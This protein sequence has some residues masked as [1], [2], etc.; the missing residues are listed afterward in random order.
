[1]R[2][3]LLPDQWLVTIRRLVAHAAVEGLLDRY[4]AN[5]N[6][7]FVIYNEDGKRVG[8]ID[9]LAI[10][11]QTAFCAMVKLVRFRVT[12][13][14]V[15]QLAPQYCDVWRGELRDEDAVVILGK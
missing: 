5:P 8:H 7:F 9:I 2:R 3:M 15:A 14:A 10:R 6:G 4:K 12:D 1:M 11:D 13:F